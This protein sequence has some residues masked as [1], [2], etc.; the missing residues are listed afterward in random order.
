MIPF[1]LGELLVQIEALDAL[2][3]WDESEVDVETEIH[4]MAEG[5]LHPGA[6][7]QAQDEGSHLMDLARRVH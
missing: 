1:L 4:A 6:F 2:S 5:G 3:E 7:S